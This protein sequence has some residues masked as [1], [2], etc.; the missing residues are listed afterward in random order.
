MSLVFLNVI[1]SPQDHVQYKKNNT[2]GHIFWM[3]VLR[4]L[5]MT[6]SK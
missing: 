4:T 2:D 6:T 5:S 1:F 3:L